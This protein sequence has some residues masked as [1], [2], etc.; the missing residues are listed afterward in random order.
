MS[1]VLVVM[2]SI[3]DSAI[4]ERATAILAEFEV[5]YSVRVLSAHRTHQALRELLDDGDDIK[6]IIAI[7]GKAAHLPGVIASLSNALVVGVPVKTSMMGGI[8]SLLSIVQ[9][10]SGVPVATVG[11]DAGENAALSAIRALMICDKTLREK[12]KV[13][14]AKMRD[15]VIADDLNYTRR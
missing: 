7:A 3:S 14:V 6:V 8:D 13:F 9:M 5:N 11:V 15:K 12:Y 10:P 2:G 4:A 1:D